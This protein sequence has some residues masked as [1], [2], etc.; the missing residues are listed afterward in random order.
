MDG[1]PILVTGSS[2]QV[3]QSVAQLAR[4]RGLETWAPDRQALDLCN[5]DA[6]AAAVARKQ[7]SAVIN[8]AAYTAVDKAESEPELADAV[9]AVAPAFL[10]REAARFAIPIVHVSTD[11][12][13]DG[14]KEE[15]Y[16]EDDEVNPLNVYGRT[17]QAGEAAVRASNPQHAIIRTAWVISAARRNFLDTM[18]R[19]G[20]ERPAVCVVDDQR[21]NPTSAADIA[22]TLLDVA[23]SLNGRS[24]TWHFVNSGDTSWHG[25][26]AHIFEQTR[27]RGL[28]TP[29]LTPITTADYPTPARRPKN[30]RLSTMAIRRDFGITPRPWQ[31]ATDAILT[32]RLG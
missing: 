30:S 23:A 14:S 17:K 18:L 8:C 25:L 4:V 6:I 20:A 10:A 29:V 3:G 7:W 9:N 22:E 27:R 31:E 16:S 21:G 24:G 5:P 32:Q 13:F 12:V 11:Y 26:A 19:L 2:G 15:P 28:P 1:R